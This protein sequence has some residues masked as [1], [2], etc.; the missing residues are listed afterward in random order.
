MEALGVTGLEG[1]DYSRPYA[2]FPVSHV[3]QSAPTLG[4][5]S[6]QIPGQDPIVRRVLPFSVFD[7]RFLPSLGLAP[8]VIDR[9][10]IAVEDSTLHVGPHR[11]PL[12]QNGQ[13]I[14]RFRGPTQTYKIESAKRVIRSELLLQ[15]GSEPII[16]PLDFADKHVF[17]GASA[18]GLMDLKPTP[19]GVGPG[20]E[21]HATLLDNLLSNDLIRDVPVAMVWLMTL[22]L[23]MVGG[24]VPMW[25]RRAWATAACVVVGASTPL[26]L[27]FLAYPAGYWL[28]IV[29]PTVTAVVALMGSVLVAYATEGRQRRFV[30]SAFSQY[31]SPV[32]I[33]QLIQDP[34][35][36]K[37]GGERRTLS[38]F[39]SDIQGFTSVSE[40]LTP[41]ALT[42]LLNTYLSALSDVIM[43]EGGTIDKFEGDAIIA[44]WNAPLDVPNHAECAVRAALKCQATL[45]TLQPQFREQTGHDIFTRIGLNTGEVV[46]GNMG[47]QRRFDYTFLGDAG[48]LAARLEGVNKVF[49]TFM[50][51]SEATRDQAGDAFAYRELS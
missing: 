34:S 3:R 7:G 36:L 46:V 15:A 48:N 33:D 13:V 21:V 41:D 32:V 35:S 29:M 14:L 31:L 42:T 43:N 40:N 5:V 28:P 23:G 45:K 1:S 2:S 11:A 47:S 12:D 50:M 44:F 17:F 4:L 30:K 19:M 26:V 20:V 9:P 27:G 25:I 37:L 22:M 10:D 16:D 39:F 38:L 6:F 51:I 8:L 49:G 24:M 18:L